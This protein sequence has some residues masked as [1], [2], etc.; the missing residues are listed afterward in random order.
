MRGL[1]ITI[2]PTSRTGVKWLTP[3]YTVDL[4]NY[5]G[6]PLAVRARLDVA[7]QNVNDYLE[8]EVVD[9]KMAGEGS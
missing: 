9:I 5:K 4:I 1:R 2:I 6:L 8:W 3:D 7:T